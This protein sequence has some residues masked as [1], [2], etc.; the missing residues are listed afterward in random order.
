[1]AQ[2][3]WYSGLVRLCAGILCWLLA[4]GCLVAQETWFPAEILRYQSKEPVAFSQLSALRRELAETSGARVAAFSQRLE[5]ALEVPALENTLQC[6]LLLLDGESA[7]IW[8][9]E[10]LR[11]EPLHEDDRTGCLLSRGAAMQLFGS[12]DITG[13]FLRIEDQDYEVRGVYEPPTAFAAFGA[14]PGRALVFAS[15]AGMPDAQDA[16]ALHFAL[17]GLSFADAQDTALLALAYAGVDAGGTF[18][19]AQTGQ[20]IRRFLISCT[21]L[22][23]LL[24]AWVFLLRAMWRALGHAIASVRAWR[25]ERNPDPRFLRGFAWRT[26]GRTAIFLAILLALLVLPVTIAQPPASYL[27][28]RWSD[29]A[30]WPA[31]ATRLSQALAATRLSGEM[32]PLLQMQSL[33]LLCLCFGIVSLIC[34]ISGTGRIQR[35]AASQG[36][37]GLAVAVTA[38]A[39]MGPLGGWLCRAAGFPVELSLFQLFLPPLLLFICFLSARINPPERG[40]A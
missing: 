8:D 11:G 40:D 29:F 31:L 12:I 35:G 6:D 21:G 16:E 2:R 18:A 4:A 5:A 13:Q 19:D 20:G 1:M 17:P 14:D 25:A 15:A 36:L 30:F 3:Q 23:L 28:T 33:S 38:T 34:C 39:A 26:G 22:W 32:R 27:P 7:L 24:A 37:A 9:L 10:M